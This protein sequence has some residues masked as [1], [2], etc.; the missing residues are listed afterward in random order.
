MTPTPARRPVGRPRGDGRPHLTRDEA[1][2]AAARL[3]SAEGY[4]G[5]SIRMIAQA[6]QKGSLCALGQT[7]PNPELSALKHFES[8]FTERL[9]TL[10]PA[11]A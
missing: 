5:A 11:E 10:E 9:K 4:T 7:A 6:M 2:L 8:E 3:I 1:L